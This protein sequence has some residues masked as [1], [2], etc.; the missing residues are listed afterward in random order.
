M[1]DRSPRILQP[2]RSKRAGVSVLALVA[3]LGVFAACA[4]KPKPTLEQR[5]EAE[6]QAF[7]TQ[8]R[9]TVTDPA[10]ADR[11][12]AAVDECERIVRQAASMAQ[13]YRTKV[14][15]LD[16]D[17]SATRAEYAA[18]FRQQGAQRA[19]LIQQALALRGQITTLTTNSEWEQLKQARL[20]ALEELLG[21]VSTP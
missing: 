11:L 7:K 2:A 3:M 8:I 6:M 16:A 20:S 17:Y 21:V 14:Q 10:R 4:S 9:K 12:V 18:L 19:A 1:R 13:D 15:A 5:A